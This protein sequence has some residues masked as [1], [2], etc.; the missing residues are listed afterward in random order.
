MTSFDQIN[1]RLGDIK[2]LSAMEMNN[3]HFATGEYTPIVPDSPET[4][5]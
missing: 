1:S 2:V 5:A 4:P 3:I